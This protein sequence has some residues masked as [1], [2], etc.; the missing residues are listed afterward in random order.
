M[1]HPYRANSIFWTRALNIPF[2]SSY[3]FQTGQPEQECG[4]SN[5]PGGSANHDYTEKLANGE[6]R[7]Y[8]Q[9]FIN[10][11]LPLVLWFT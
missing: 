7:Y 2:P 8:F 1:K 5:A 9:Q 4:S 6:N 10:F 3:V 11:I